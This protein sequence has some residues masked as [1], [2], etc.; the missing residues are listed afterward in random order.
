MITKQLLMIMN[1][2]DIRIDMYILVYI[3]KITNKD[4]LYS[5]G[6]ST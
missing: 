5:T 6:N 2:W 4:L 1:T 3:K